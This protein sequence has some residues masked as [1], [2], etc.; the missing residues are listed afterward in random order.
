MIHFSRCQCDG[1]KTSGGV[2]EPQ[3]DH[4]FPRNR[5]SPSYEKFCAQRQSIWKKSHCGSKSG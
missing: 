5:Q 4:H 2:R 1:R 3:I